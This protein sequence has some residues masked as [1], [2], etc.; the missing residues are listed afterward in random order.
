VYAD[1]EGGRMAIPLELV[2]RLE[3][4]PRTELESSGPL[5]VVQYG[6]EILHLVDIS[7]VMLERRHTSRV[8]GL[9]S[10]GENL[11]VLVYEH[12]G[13]RVGVVCGQIVDVIHHDLV[14]LQ[15]GSRPGV[16]GT[17]V[18]DGRV[19]EVLD[20]PQ[21]LSDWDEDTLAALTLEELSA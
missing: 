3:E 20:L 19:T 6:E 1:H 9:G 2:T 11:P 16:A 8:D 18:L 13:R 12:E 15:P 10:S 21:I 7:R 17:M 14:E 4:F 5:P